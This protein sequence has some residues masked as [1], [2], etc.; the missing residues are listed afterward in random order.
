MILDAASILVYG[1]KFATKWPKRTYTA[2]LQL[3]ECQFPILA[4][5]ASTSL[6]KSPKYTLRWSM[7]VQALSSAGTQTWSREERMT[8]WT[9]KTWHKSL[10][11]A[12]ALVKRSRCLA[13]TQ[14]KKQATL[15]WS[16]KS[17]LL[18]LSKMIPIRVMYF[19]STAT[20]PRSRT[21][22]VCS[23]PLVWVI[24][25]T[26]KWWTRATA[27]GGV[28]LVARPSPVSDQSIW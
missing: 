10:E 25:A 21:Q 15:T 22:I 3:R 7:N 26:K 17:I 12:T 4:A 27:S 24:S 28:K 5:R 9:F 19:S 14:L 18:S 1:E 13:K 23:I 2:F 16:V 20:W 6:T 11:S 8:S